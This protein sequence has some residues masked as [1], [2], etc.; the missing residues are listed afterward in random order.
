MTAQEARELT[1][2]NR[3]DELLII[4]KKIEERIR[5]GSFILDY[6]PSPYVWSIL[7]SMGYKI[8]N[9]RQ[10]DSWK[11]FIHWGSNLTDEA[12]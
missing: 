11:R 3:E 8:L 7:E 12:I 9:K 4:E 5:G 1:I 2:K 10:G 6:T